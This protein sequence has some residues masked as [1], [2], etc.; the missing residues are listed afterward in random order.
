MRDLRVPTAAFLL[1]AAAIA[2]KLI[3]GLHEPSHH[4]VEV[5]VSCALICILFHGGM[6]IGWDRLRPAAGP[7]AVVGV[8]GTVVTVA[9]MALL[10]RYG[11]SVSWYASLLLATA[12]APTDPAVV[13]AV[14]G[15]RVIPGRASTILEGESGAND[16]VGIALMASLISAGSLTG[17][18][19]GS[20]AGK[21]F[22]QMGVGLAF[23]VVGG[24][25]LHLL[26]HRLTLTRPTLI[27]NWLYAA[28]TLVLAFALFGVADL[29][30]G[31]GFLAVFVA[32]ILIGDSDAPG[33][34]EV[35]RLQGALASLSE[36]VAFLVLGLTVDLAELAHRNVWLPGV[37]LGAALAF[38][39][40]PLL[41][42]PC[43]LPARLPGPERIFVLLCGLKGAVPLLLGTSLL[44]AC[45]ADPHRLYGIVVVIVLFS[46]VVQGVMVAPLVKRLWPTAS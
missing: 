27:S 39:V 35:D 9:G 31:S 40:R 30:K 2:V 13:F 12:V 33:K 28:I 29:A 21:F 7:I 8:L 32:G 44:T 36:I 10:I 34:S 16:P 4:V 11:L 5:V 45:V 14:L 22:L 41:V 25:L 43:L 15:K 42:A 19:A 38:V 3:P 26:F 1:L 37:L 24:A 20:V 18:A 23:G 17:D 46:V 6:H